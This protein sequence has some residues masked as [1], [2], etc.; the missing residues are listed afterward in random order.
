MTESKP[1]L[2]IEDNPDDRA[3]TLRALKDIAN[4]FITASDGAAALALLQGKDAKKLPSV[5]LLDL[6]LPKMG[7]LEILRRMREDERTALIPVVVLTSSP[8]EQDLSESF[9]AGANSFIRKPVDFSRF[10]AAVRPLGL[11]WLVLNEAR[12]KR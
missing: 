6:N 1:I 4:E 8:D 5:V 9:K 2:L 7:G 10:A 3:L 11:S 12:P